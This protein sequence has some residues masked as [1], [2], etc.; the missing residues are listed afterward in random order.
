MVTLKGNFQ[1]KYQI[2]PDWKPA[3]AM[4][5]VD[6]PCGP[7]IG[8]DDDASRKKNVWRF[9]LV[10]WIGGHWFKLIVNVGGCKRHERDKA[11]AYLRSRLADRMVRRF[12]V[13]EIVRPLNDDLRR[14]IDLF[15]KILHEDQ[16][17]LRNRKRLG[18]VGT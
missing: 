4:V 16:E 5:H 17:Y 12:K 15:N 14:K 9:W 13:C 8:V 11:E 3:G 6:F 18:Y 7:F 10:C 1:N 2:K